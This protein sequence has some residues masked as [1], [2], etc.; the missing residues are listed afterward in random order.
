MIFCS[1]V[2]DI[3]TTSIKGALID[4]YGKVYKYG[5]LFFPQNVEAKNWYNSFELL[6]KEFEVFADS[7]QG[8]KICGICVSGNGPTLVAVSKNR[9]KLFLWNEKIPKNIKLTKT[10]NS[11]SIFMPR[12]EA[13]SIVY[14]EI[15][16][17]ADFILSGQ[18]FLIYKLTGK[19]ITVLPE[20]RYQKAYWISSDLK[21]FNIKM[22]PFI[23]AGEN[24]GLYKGIPVFAGVPDFI[25]ALIGTNTIKP[26]KACDRAGSSEGLNICVETLPPVEK[27]QNLRILPSPVYPYWNISFIIPNSGIAF[28][29]YLKEN[30][31]TSDD[32][33]KFMEEISNLPHCKKG[34][35]PK[36]KAGIGRQLIENLAAEVK[37]GMDLLESA[38]GFKPVYTICGGQAKNIIWCKM[39]MEITGRKFKILKLAD[40]ELLGNAAIVFTSLKEYTDITNAAEQITGTEQNPYKE[41]F[42]NPI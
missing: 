10:E 7:Y 17:N 24:C 30:G 3:G 38:S 22:P 12:I 23:P 25:A 9:E 35:Y 28:Y 40:A 27:L 5:R 26:G 31:G 16:E 20:D 42:K 15:F 33:D 37:Y 36:T 34:C 4:K 41:N 8:L 11:S 39:K 2:F 6:F 13:L 21:L 14:P 19:K 18:E 29:N 1:A 32:F